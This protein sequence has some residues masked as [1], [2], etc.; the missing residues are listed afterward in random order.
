MDRFSMTD[1]VKRT[2]KSDQEF[3]E[4]QFAGLS[5]FLATV[6]RL[7]QEGLS[8][9]Q[10]QML[11]ECPF[12]RFGRREC[13]E[14]LVLALALARGTATVAEWHEAL[15]NRM[16]WARMHG[17]VPRLPTE[18]LPDLAAIDAELGLPPGA[19]RG[20]RPSARA[21]RSD[22]PSRTVGSDA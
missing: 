17:S 5:V 14:T 16:V 3:N 8:Q 4:L 10:L 1:L 12:S 15:R 2:L 7:E 20:Q 9:Q 19:W 22:W 21:S 11:I 6:A 13:G 18:T